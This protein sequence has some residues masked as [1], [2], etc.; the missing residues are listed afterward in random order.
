MKIILC[1]SLLLLVFVNEIFSQANCSNPLP[2]SV[3]PDTLLLNQTNS[4]MVDDAPV[5]INYTGEDLVYQITVPVTTIKIFI[6]IANATGLI[7]AKLVKDSCTN[8][9]GPAFPFNT[10]TN[11]YTFIVSNS[12]TYYLWLDAATAVTFD[13][14]IGADTSSTFVSHPDTQGDWMPDQSGCYVPVFHTAKAFYQVKFNNVF[15]TDPMTLAPLNV[16]GSFCINTI[17]KNTTGDEGV[18]KFEFSFGTGYINI[19]APDSIAGTYNTGY[20]IKSGTGNFLKYIFY[21]AASIGRG[22]FDGSPNA[23]LSYEFCF[24]LIPISNSPSITEVNVYVESDGYGAAYTGNLNSGCCPAFFPNCHF[25]L[26]GSSSG[27]NGF[28][29]GVN[30]PGGSLPVELVK[31]DVAEENSIVRISWT[32]ASEINNDYFTIE[33]SGDAINWKELEQTDGSGNSTQYLDYAII[34]PFPLS[35]TS[36]YRLKQTDFDG[37]ISVFPPKSVHHD[38]AKDFDVFPNPAKEKFTIRNFSEGE[39]ETELFSAMGIQVHTPVSTTSGEKIFDT[40][41]LTSGIYFLIIRSENE[42][43]KRERI[44][45]TK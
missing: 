19:Q 2:V 36:Y 25:N 12:T 29:F 10:G 8:I 37:K 38:A 27:V 34:D 9:S 44:I 24:P 5:G 40:S 31:F 23:C 11:L 18:R 33:R 41:Q 21:D 39:Y 32:T 30:D 13:I 1:I 15:Q 26:G 6:S 20:W 45:I 17:L 14:G 7:R 3:C 43:K 22:D 16:A 42:I 28:G 35:G 4:G